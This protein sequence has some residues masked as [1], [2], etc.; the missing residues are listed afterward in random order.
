M[1]PQLP[2]ITVGDI[3]SPVY[4]TVQTWGPDKQSR[5]M[6]VWNW[7]RGSSVGPTSWGPGVRK[8]PFGASWSENVKYSG[9][10]IPAQ[11]AFR[12][13]TRAINDP[14]IANVARSSSYPS[15]SDQ[16]GP[17]WMS[18]LGQLDTGLSA[19]M[20]GGDR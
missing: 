4:Q 20:F 13:A 12:G 11:Q 14:W 17:P 3:N 9:D 18:Y 5:R 8:A 15:G 10:D 19:G 1:R 16:I 6:A 7:M 2:G